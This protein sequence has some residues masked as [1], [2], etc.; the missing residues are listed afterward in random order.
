MASSGSPNFTP[1]ES[2]ASGSSS[3]IPALASASGPV[4]ADGISP[5]PPTEPQP[6]PL[7]ENP[8]A[9]TTEEGHV[10]VVRMNDPDL[11]IHHLNQFDWLRRDRVIIQFDPSFDSPNPDR[12][13]MM[14]WDNRHVC[15]IPLVRRGVNIGEALEYILG[16]FVDS[17]RLAIK[18]KYKAIPV[19][20][21]DQVAALLAAFHW[22]NPESVQRNMLGNRLFWPYVCLPKIAVRLNGTWEESLQSQT[23]TELAPMEIRESVWNRCHSLLQE[24]YATGRVPEIPYGAETSW[25]CLPLQLLKEVYVVDEL[26]STD[27]QRQYVTP[28]DE[29]PSRP[30]YVEINDGADMTIPESDSEHMY[31]VPPPDVNLGE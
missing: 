19:W 7:P 30:P 27:W 22:I 26:H 5:I 31:M 17:G 29:L 14:D 4:D 6:A 9:E 21:L 24:A 10:F 25:E 11:N 1:G 23:T 28:V 16:A 12:T 8:S 18:L 20:R 13:H 3:A 15:M 2:S